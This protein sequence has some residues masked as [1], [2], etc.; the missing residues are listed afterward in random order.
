MK[1]SV[2]ISIFCLFLITSSLAL[3]STKVDG[4]R[5]RSGPGKSYSV[6]MDLPKYYPLK[7]VARSGA[8]RKVVDWQNTRGWV[9]K[10]TLSSQRTAIVRKLR[11]NLRS[12]PG[13]RYRR[14]SRLFKGYTLKIIKYYGAWYKVKVVDPPNGPTGWIYRTLIWG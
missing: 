8:W 13:T 3:P 7:I 14:V 11:V 12:G 1:K 9:H 6:K 10:S 4:V 5:L 2:L